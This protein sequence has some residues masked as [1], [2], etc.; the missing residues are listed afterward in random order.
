MPVLAATPPTEAESPTSAV[1]PQQGAVDQAKLANFFFRSVLEQ[2]T[3]GTLIMSADLSG[4]QGPRVMFQTTPK[5][6]LAGV[7]PVNG[8]RDVPLAKLAA[9][10]EDAAEL[11]Q[12]E[13]TASLLDS[14]D[15]VGGL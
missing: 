13:R 1:A 6:E 7:A 10:P 3:E 8:L 12:A 4:T 9:T 2:D 5:A 11:L 14:A 15:W